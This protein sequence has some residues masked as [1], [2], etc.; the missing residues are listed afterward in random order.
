M[1]IKNND[2]I[3]EISKNMFSLSSS[4]IEWVESVVDRFS[5]NH[6]YNDINSDIFDE[7]M[8]ESF[9]DA[10]LIHH[11]LSK[12]A[13]SKDKFE[14]NEVFCYDWLSRPPQGFREITFSE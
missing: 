11:S 1:T 12:E 7:C 13:F 5:M 9:G 10:L 4:Q 2:R 8:L 3:E 14:S 6:Y